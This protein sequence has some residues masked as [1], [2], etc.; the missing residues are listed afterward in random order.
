[1]P[2]LKTRRSLFHMVSFWPSAW[3]TAGTTWITAGT[4]CASGR[5]TSYTTR[6]LVSRSEPAQLDA[7]RVTSYSP[8]WSKAWLKLG[9]ARVS[10]TSS[11]SLTD[12]CQ[13]VGLVSPPPPPPP[14][15]P[16][17][18]TMKVRP[19]MV[20]LPLRWPSAGLLFT[21]YRRR[22]APIS[23]GFVVIAIH[24]LCD[25][26]VHSQSAWVETSTAPVPPSAS[27]LFEVGLMA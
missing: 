8:T 13:S 3:I 14:P 25:C 27:K 19:A 22:A 24:G 17:W 4:T 7:C 18:R 11:P 15:V 2:G 23:F 26:A 6:V 1:V 12:H 20:M 16:A 5:T 9:V 10:R 21:W